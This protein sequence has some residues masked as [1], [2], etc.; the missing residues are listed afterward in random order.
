MPDDKIKRTTQRSIVPSTDSPVTEPLKT[1]IKFN[2]SQ[3]NLLPFVRSNSVRT[4]PKRPRYVELRSR[5]EKQMAKT[6]ESF[7]QE[8]DAME[9]LRRDLR[10][11]DVPR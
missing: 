9:V 7:Q 10:S 11:P 8:E 2:L 5:R 3:D 1:A 4:P 6:E